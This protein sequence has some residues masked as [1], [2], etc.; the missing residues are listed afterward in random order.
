MTPAGEELFCQ[1]SNRKCFKYLLVFSQIFREAFFVT[2]L[3]K[4]L[5]DIDS[6]V[7]WELKYKYI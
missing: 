2:S 6:F 1:L 4:V 7:D 3:K 5:R